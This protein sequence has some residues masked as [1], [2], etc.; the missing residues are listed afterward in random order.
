M[1]VEWIQAGVYE[2]YPTDATLFLHSSLYPSYVWE[3][4]IESTAWRVISTLLHD[5][6]N[7]KAY[8][9]LND[10]EHKLAYWILDAIIIWTRGHPESDEFIEHVS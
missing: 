3:Y 2:S 8:T 7:G 6:N 4:R 5:Q 10:T 1:S 9:F